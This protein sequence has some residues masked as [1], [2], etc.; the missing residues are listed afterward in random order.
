MDRAQMTEVG[1]QRP[2]FFPLSVLCFLFS[3]FCFSGCTNDMK[4]QPRFEAYEES[5]F[6]TDGR[7]VRPAIEGTVAR[8]Q[9]RE[10]DAFYTGKSEGKFVEKI[11]IDITEDVLKR[12]QQRYKIY[13]IVCHDA[14]GSG[15]GMIIKRG[16]K[17]APTSFHSERLR[18]MP[19]GYF[20]D[21]ITKGYGSMTDYSMQLEPADRWAVTAYIRAL[22]LSQ[23]V[24]AAQLAAADKEKLAGQKS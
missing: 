19:S 6:F 12:G 14:A 17:P 2:V 10:D 21:V 5:P 3:F 1:S 20:Y 22:Q 8:G 11:P 9:L 4:D 7:S 16:F 18:S 13:C 15:S 23:N 24:P